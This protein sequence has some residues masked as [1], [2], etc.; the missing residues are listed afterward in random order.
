[1]GGTKNH[2]VRATVKLWP[3]GEQPPEHLRREVRRHCWVM[4]D[5][6][7]PGLI[8]E[9]QRR[10][11]GVWE[12]RVVYLTHWDPEHRSTTKERW[13]GQYDLRPA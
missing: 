2:E 3:R 13:V 5:G 11:S 6:P 9:W 4:D 10:P 7:K 1:M 8:I 12:A